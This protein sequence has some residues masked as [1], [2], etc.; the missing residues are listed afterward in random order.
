MM[1]NVRTRPVIPGGL[2]RFVAAAGVALAVVSSALPAL[3]ANPEALKKFEEGKKHRADGDCGKAVTFFEE[4]V[5]IEATIGGHY[6][7]GYCY[8]QLKQPEKAYESYKR[9][10]K[11]AQE[12]KDPREEEI[13]D[14]TIRTRDVV[15]WVR[16]DVAKV[17]KA[18]GL[19]VTVDGEV[20]PP[21]EYTAEVILRKSARHEIVVSATGHKDWTVTNQP[22]HNTIVLEL[23]EALVEAK[24]KETPPPPPEPKG[25]D[26]STQRVASII[27][28]GVGGVGLVAGGA[29]GLYYLVEKGD[30]ETTA[31]EAQTRCV[32]TR[33]PEAAALGENIQAFCNE[34]E[35][36]AKSY[37]DWHDRTV[38]ATWVTIPVSAALLLGGVVLFVTAP[39]GK[40]VAGG[41]RVRLVPEATPTTSGLHLHGTF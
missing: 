5:A 2:R 32:K 41:V 38:L 28:M 9:A 31:G 35:P 3:A 10:L 12:K 26:G 11:L 24:P 8:E 40:E 7:L 34:N 30:R 4:S 18:P 33:K 16:L 1:A 6:N 23:G 21:A 15:H 39:R 29:L 25:S 27:L 17:Q 14:A 37:L 20:V 19:R 13:R 36:G 22:D